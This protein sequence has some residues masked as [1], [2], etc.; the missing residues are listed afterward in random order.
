MAIFPAAGI[1]YDGVG[2][3]V[4]FDLMIGDSERRCAA[5]LLRL[6]GRSFADAE[7]P[8]EID[9]PITQDDLAGAANL[10]RSSAGAASPSAD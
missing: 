9:V 6:S 5:V 10:S 8:D 3:R 1:H 7:G 4:A 2:F